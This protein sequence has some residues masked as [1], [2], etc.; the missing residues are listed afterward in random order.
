MSQLAVLHARSPHGFP[1][2]LLSESYKTSYYIPAGVTDAKIAHENVP[3]ASGL[4]ILPP[5]LESLETSPMT[6]EVNISGLPPLRQGH[7]A[8]VA[9]SRLLQ[10]TMDDMANGSDVESAFFVANLGQVY[11]QFIRWKRCLP[12]IEPFYGTAPL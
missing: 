5:S 6:P 7:P 2:A 9:R 8:H 10:T 12:D 11:K 1:D 4:P 3:R